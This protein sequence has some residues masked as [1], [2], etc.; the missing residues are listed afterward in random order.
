[1]KRTALQETESALTLAREV[2]GWLLSPLAYLVAVAALVVYLCLAAV[3]GLV[4][5]DDSR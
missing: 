2:V 5:D 1:V 3:V 4:V